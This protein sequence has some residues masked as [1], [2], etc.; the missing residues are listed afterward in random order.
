MQL[1]SQ[2][3]PSTHDKPKGYHL[4]NTEPAMRKEANKRPQK[5]AHGKEASGWLRGVIRFFGERTHGFG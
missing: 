2:V 1:V 4:P 5:R 3:Y